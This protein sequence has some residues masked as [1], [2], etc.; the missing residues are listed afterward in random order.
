M[1]LKEKIDQRR[2]ERLVDAKREVKVAPEQPKTQGQIE[3]ERM[4]EKAR[5]KLAFGS[6]SITEQDRLKNEALEVINQIDFSSSTVKSNLTRE[7]AETI[8]EAAAHQSLLLW[9]RILMLLGPAIG[10]YLGITESWALGITV[11][12]GG[13]MLAAVVGIFLE[14]FKKSQ[15]I[16]EHKLERLAP[17]VHDLDVLVKSEKQSDV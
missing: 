11:A 4:T 6:L 17:K 1:D 5:A 2:K 8:V 3:R 15:L 14:K 9:G 10:L 13:V 16:E 7:D 12:S